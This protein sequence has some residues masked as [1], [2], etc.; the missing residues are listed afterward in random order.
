MKRPNE[1]DDVPENYKPNVIELG[2]L[3]SDPLTYLSGMAWDEHGDVAH[4]M[5]GAH[6]T[7]AHIMRAGGGMVYVAIHMKQGQCSN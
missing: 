1:F 3:E 2:I 6:R 7:I 5:K 4:D